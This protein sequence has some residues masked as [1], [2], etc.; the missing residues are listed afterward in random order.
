MV[1]IVTNI[2][3][4][5]HNNISGKIGFYFRGKCQILKGTDE[6]RHYW[7]TGKI[8]LFFNLVGFSQCI[9]IEQ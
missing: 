5:C 8:R 2:H 3:N 4:I 7:V 6:Q 9:S 1:T